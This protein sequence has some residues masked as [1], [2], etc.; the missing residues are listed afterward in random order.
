MTFIYVVMLKQKE[1]PNSKRSG[2]TPGTLLLFLI[3]IM[4]LSISLVSPKLITKRKCKI[5]L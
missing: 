3:Q 1:L 5:K 4:H 2:I